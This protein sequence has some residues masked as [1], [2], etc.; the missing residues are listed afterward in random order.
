MLCTYVKPVRLRLKTTGTA[1]PAH[2]DVL[3]LIAGQ[4]RHGTDKGAA[5]MATSKQ[6]N[7]TYQPVAA[8]L[9]WLH[10]WKR[11]SASAGRSAGVRPALGSAPVSAVQLVVDMLGHFGA[12]TRDLAQLFDTGAHHLLHAAQVLEQSLA[13]LWTNAAYRLKL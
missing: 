4:R 8:R 1:A 13:A 6:F 3:C 12:D 10:A 5:G 11:H 7:A 9:M 2:L